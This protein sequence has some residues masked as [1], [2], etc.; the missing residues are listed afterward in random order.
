[1]KVKA[2]SEKSILKAFWIKWLL[3]VGES[4]LLSHS[5]S[6]GF[7][8]HVLWSEYTWYETEGTEDKNLAKE[9]GTKEKEGKRQTAKR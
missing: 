3:L 1:M 2:L 8:F 7:A 9:T 4:I 6:R 5:S